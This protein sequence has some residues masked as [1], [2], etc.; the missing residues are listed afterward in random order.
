MLALHPLNPSMNKIRQYRYL[1][2]KKAKNIKQPLVAHCKL[3]AL[4]QCKKS[5]TDTLFQL[6]FLP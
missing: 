4:K 5:R 1:I 6:I 3:T 2:I